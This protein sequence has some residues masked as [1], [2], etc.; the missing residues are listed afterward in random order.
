MGPGSR[1][2]CL[3]SLPVAS[4]GDKPSYTW[5]F[6]CSVPS[7]AVKPL[8][9]MFPGPEHPLT[10]V[11]R[12]ADPLRLGSELN[13]LG[14]DFLSPAGEA[15]SLFLQPKFVGLLSYAERPT[16]SQN[17]GPRDV[18][19]AIPSREVSHSGAPVPA[20]MPVTAVAHPCRRSYTLAAALGCHVYFANSFR[21]S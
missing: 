11:F 18:Q 8:T 12:L 6:K 19:S 14:E 21:S 15:H 1:P 3:T 10:L 5:V 13:S 16:V 2:F 4:P 9:R 20:L 17:K 7:L